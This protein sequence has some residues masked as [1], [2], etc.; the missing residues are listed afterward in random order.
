MEVV[1]SVDQ[2]LLPKR[3]EKKYKY[4]EISESEKVFV[5]YIFLPGYALKI[6]EQPNNMMDFIVTP[7]LQHVLSFFGV[8]GVDYSSIAESLFIPMGL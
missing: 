2:L 5:D 6:L 3:G 4:S 1:F 8:V 7:S